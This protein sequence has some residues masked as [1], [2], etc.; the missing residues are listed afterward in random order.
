MVE[1]SELRVFIASPGGLDEERDTVERA[2]NALNSL[3]SDLLDVTIRVYRWEQLSAR[4]GRP[5]ALIN[6]WVDECDL[7]IG[8][9]HRRWGSPAGSSYETG[10][11]E[12]IARAL[13]RHKREGKPE[14]ALY[15]KSVDSSSLADPGPELARVL[16]FQREMRGEHRLRYQGFDSFE[17]LRTLITLRLT[18]AMHQHGRVGATGEGYAPS[19]SA[20]EVQSEVAEAPHRGADDS[21]EL[22]KTLDRFSAAIKGNKPDGKLD[23]DR[24]LLFASAA[25]RDRE[26]IPT[27]LANRLANR[28][29][30]SD[31]RQVEADAW[32]RSLVADVGRSV[33]ATERVFPFGVFRDRESLA[34]ALEALLPHLMDDGLEHVSVGAARLLLG[35]GIRPRALVGRSRDAI[36][37]AELR[38][39][40]LFRTQPSVAIRLW[41]RFAQPADRRF[42]RKL[43]K[44]DSRRAAELGIAL[45]RASGTNPNLDALVDID[46]SILLDHDVRDFVGAP[47]ESLTSSERLSALVVESATPSAARLVALNELIVRSV[48]ADSVVDHLTSPESRRGTDIE[49]DR[50]ERRFLTSISV[51]TLLASL[52]RLA[53]PRSDRVGLTRIRRWRLATMG[54]PSEARALAMSLAQGAGA[55]Q[56]EARFATHATD[57]RYKDEAL[58]IVKGDPSPLSEFLD[59]PELANYPDLRSYF[60]DSVSY[61]AVQYLSTLKGHRISQNEI[62]VLR[63]IVEKA[64]LVSDDARALLEELGS[65]EDLE[66]VV[67]SAR[68]RFE[69]I[70]DSLLERLTLTQLRA[71]VDGGDGSKTQAGL[72]ELSRRER[73]MPVKLLRDLMRRPDADVRIA[74]A[75]QL[76]Q[77]IEPNQIADERRMYVS[78][79]D[80]YYYNVV[81]EL[82]RAQVGLPVGWPATSAA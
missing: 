70:N 10:F 78:A 23:S 75:R 62:S 30:V 36:E 27:H 53:A 20:A 7:F 38:W 44:G 16:E 41:C 39:G 68:S 13:E 77:K 48:H 56:S 6:P 82:E 81:C 43:V 22:V 67:N 47:P 51:S 11:H 45:T 69:S 74:A 2:A 35:L 17:E 65:S 4:A 29:N 37:N 25:S 79:K 80:T 46:A 33:G 5:Q 26:L 1:K 73:F 66:F 28:V 58:A 71:W 72:R 64:D 21:D 24:L 34:K 8:V 50:V 3:L 18:E 49:T 63:A 57:P 52:E 60:S 40:R 55:T 19:R 42:L 76:L 32:L 61:M 31:L 15:F 14:I 12:E 54:I 9:L 59:A